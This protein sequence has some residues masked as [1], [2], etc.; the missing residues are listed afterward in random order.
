MGQAVRHI[1]PERGYWRSLSFPRKCLNPLAQGG[2]PRQ[3]T[4]FPETAP[5]LLIRYAQARGGPHSRLVIAGILTVVFHLGLGQAAAQGTHPISPAEMGEAELGLIAYA[6]ELPPLSLCPKTGTRV[7]AWETE[8]LP[9]PC[10]KWLP[11]H[12]LERNLVTQDLMDIE[13]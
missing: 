10:R 3:G 2:C 6:R 1:G 11:S 13:K 12:K 9:L 5:Y 8:S 4:W 7:V